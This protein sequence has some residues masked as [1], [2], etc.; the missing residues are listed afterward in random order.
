MALPLLVATGCDESSAGDGDL[1]LGR[2]DAFHFCDAN[3][4]E[5]VRMGARWLAC[6]AD[7]P[8][9]VPP[10]DTEIEGDLMTCPST[11]PRR[12][13]GVELPGPGRYRVEALAN[14]TAGDSFTECFVDPDTGSTEVELPR[15]RLDGPSPLV[16]EEHQPCP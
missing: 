1:V 9:C 6:A 5:S 14:H 4:I 2:V 3:G 10:P 12:E 13:L 15:G 8:D 7:E 16:L 11:S